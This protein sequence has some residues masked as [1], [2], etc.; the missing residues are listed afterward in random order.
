LESQAVT[1]TDLNLLQYLLGTQ[2]NNAGGCMQRFALVFCLFL[3]TPC[4]A[5]DIKSDALLG[6]IHAEAKQYENTTFATHLRWTSVTDKGR[7]DRI[8]H[9]DPAKGWTYI[10][11][12]GKPP[13]EKQ[14]KAMAEAMKGQHPDGYAVV[15]DFLKDNRW[16]ASVQNETMVVYT[17]AVDD[18]SKV[19]INDI[20][21]A[22]YLKTQITVQLGDKP[23]V[24]SLTMV[25]P[26]AFSPRM[27]ATVKSLNSSYSFDRRA[28]GDVVPVQET[29]KAD[30]KVVL[31]RNKMDDSRTYSDVGKRVPKPAKT[32]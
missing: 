32:P 13:E 25:A 5:A 18:N 30:F 2:I 16:T 17:L 4:Q 23:F 11:R 8:V 12:N 20:N 3:T 15:A 22:K 9:F 19:M 29:N 14:L 31:F 6:K 7:A 1:A 27:G 21:M 28:D 24:K 26:A 10:S